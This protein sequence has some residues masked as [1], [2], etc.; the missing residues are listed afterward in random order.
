[1][2]GYDAVVE[3]GRVRLT[4]LA[5][6]DNSGSDPQPLLTVTYDGTR[7]LI[8]DRENVVPYQLFKN[9]ARAT[10]PVGGGPALAVIAQ[11]LPFDPRAGYWQSL[12]PNARQMQAGT[13]LGRPAQKYS[14]GKR[15]AIWVDKASGIALGPLVP[16]GAKFTTNPSIDATTFGTI[17]PAGAKVEVFS[18]APKPRAKAPNFTVTELPKFTPNDKPTAGRPISSREFA[19]RPYVLAFFDENILFDPNG[20]EISSLRTLDELTASG[21]RPVVLGVLLTDTELVDKSDLLASAGW[22]FRIAYDD[23]RVQHKFG[24]MDELDFAFIKADGT[25]A[26]LHSGV[27]SKPQLQKAIAA[28]N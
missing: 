28:L 26:Q 27:M 21:T 2:L 10:S 22:H 20:P 5:Y 4:I 9:A 14:C 8:H 12:C 25:I 15:P 1:M 23:T 24:F 19:G 6:A 7:E 18:T 16:T 11:F 17:P 3:H 13:D